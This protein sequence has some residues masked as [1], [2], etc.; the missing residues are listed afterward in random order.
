MKERDTEMSRTQNF[1]PLKSFKEPYSEF[2]NENSIKD[3]HLKFVNMTFRIKSQEG[4][5]FSQEIFQLYLNT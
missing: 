1:L 2:N 3:N 4:I 5:L